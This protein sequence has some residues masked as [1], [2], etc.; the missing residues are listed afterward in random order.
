[1]NFRKRSSA[2]L[3]QIGTPLIHLFGPC[4]HDPKVAREP[5]EALVRAILISS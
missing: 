1:M 3:L 5:Y 2:I 4:L